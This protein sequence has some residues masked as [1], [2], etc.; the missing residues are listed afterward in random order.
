MNNS[1]RLTTC[2]RRL[3]NTN[4]GMV[5]TTGPCLGFSTEAKAVDRERFEKGDTMAL[6]ARGVGFGKDAAGSV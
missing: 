5:E 6:V 4:W 2:D 1:Y 3:D